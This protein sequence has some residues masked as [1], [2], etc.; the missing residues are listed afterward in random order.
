MVKNRFLMINNLTHNKTIL[1]F[2]TFAYVIFSI[3]VINQYS[4]ALGNVDFYRY[5]FGD[6]NHHISLINKIDAKLNLN[7]IH[8]ADLYY[9]NYY[10]FSL[11]I[12]KLLKIFPGSDYT[13]VGISAVII[14]LI[15][16]YTICIACYLIC[17]NLSKSK[18]FSIGIVCLLWSFDLLR[19]S[20]RI[21]P[22]I[23]Q[24]SLI[25]LSVY[26]V[27][28]NNKYKW[29]LSFVFCGLA[30]GV[31]AQ[32]LL[33][34]IYLISFYFFYE[35]SNKLKR[36][37]TKVVITI[38]L[39]TFLYTLIFLITFFS[40]NQL[41]PYK[42]AQSILS[43][44]S[45]S[46][47]IQSFDNTKIVYNYFIYLLR[48]K[49]N[50]II[51]IAAIILNLFLLIS[52]K[53]ID[54]LFFVSLAFLILFYYQIFNFSQLV[55]GPRYLYHFL[56]LIIICISSIFNNICE[57]L[58]EKNLKI[59]PLLCALLVFG[60]GIVIFKNTFFKVLPRYDFKTKIKKDDMF[61][62]YYF[63]KENIKTNIKDPLVCA[64]HY[65]LI[66]MNFSKNIRKSYRHLDFE[67]SILNKECEYILLDSSTPG[68]YI[69]FKGR[70]DNL[71]IRKY[72]NLNNHHKLFGKEKIEKTQ[73]LIKYLLQDPR[74]G[75]VV[76]YYNPKMI[77]LSKK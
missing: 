66:P 33:I 2:F 44:A 15:S 50:F 45:R 51:F 67:K 26:F 25:F 37:N 47:D 12:L 5:F 1:C 54:I 4:V 70:L 71:I 6:G 76:T 28:T 59:I 13:L 58:N 3:Y 55:Q 69:W 20:L 56:P 32:G 57:Y 35:C 29:L 52:R 53:K 61:K 23:L 75:Y 39:Y 63:F 46:S 34:F 42:F 68:R 21:Y 24:L 60:H 17:Y 22:D 40:L 9:N 62:G 38:F 18:F 10:I 27:S 14:N 16:I 7:K 77:I 11:A 19:F 43:A 72:E 73:E 31:K 8:S 64:G 74:S 65:S 41:D 49:A 30:F 36:I 48:D